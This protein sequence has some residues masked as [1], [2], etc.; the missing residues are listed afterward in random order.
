MNSNYRTLSGKDLSE[1]D[2]NDRYKEYRE[3][4]HTN[5]EKFIVADFPLFLDIEATSACNLKCSH[6]GQSHTEFKRGFMPISIYRRVIDEASAGG[7]YGCKYHTIGRGEPLIHKQIVS[8]VSYAKK[9]GLID[10]YLNTNGQYL[11]SR[12]IRGLLDVG[13]DRI[14]ISVDGYTK[15]FY[16]YRRGASWNNLL[17][18]IVELKKQRDS[19]NYGTSIRVQTV[20]L[21][22]LD[23]KEYSK[24]WKPYAD[25]V[26]V[27]SYKDMRN[28]AEG[29]VDKDWHCPQPWQRMSVLWTGD[30]ILCNHDDRL[31]SKM[32]NIRSD[33]LRKVWGSSAANYMRGLHRSGRSEFL[34]ACEGCFLRTS[35]IRVKNEKG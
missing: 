6:C 30:L 3:K 23:L 16:E 17:R 25:E 10:V 31:L 33:T 5:P 4:W 35:E 20:A 11:N 32:G 14:S 8:M 2:N 15:K 26:G 12:M 9:K 28:R 13:I 21:K 27:V 1:E 29:L 19:K 22:T 24:F 34:S 7:C 18:N